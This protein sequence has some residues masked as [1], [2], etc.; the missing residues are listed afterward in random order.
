MLTF[1]QQQAQDKLAL[2]DAAKI[3]PR[4]R[5]ASGTHRVTVRLDDGTWGA[6]N[7]PTMHRAGVWAVHVT[8]STWSVTHTP[9]GLRVGAMRVEAYAYAMV[10]DLGDRYPAW[11][12]SL[13]WGDTI[14]AQVA[15][16]AAEVRAI[17][18]DHMERDRRGRVWLWAG[19][20]P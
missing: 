7:V 3:K 19:F 14:G 6:R 4:G 15:D 8:A 5:A 20:G 10:A 12:E 9:T 1:R 17:A 13:A 18:A 11:G 16:A 2:K